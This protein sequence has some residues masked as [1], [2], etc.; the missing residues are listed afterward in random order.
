MKTTTTSVYLSFP[1]IPRG[2]CEFIN[3]PLEGAVRHSEASVT[4]AGAYGDSNPST[5]AQ[6]PS[7]VRFRASVMDAGVVR[8]YCENRT[9]YPITLAPAAYVVNVAA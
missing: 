6:Q 1:T 2:S 9:D 4:Y 5:L 8:V 3:V 7:G